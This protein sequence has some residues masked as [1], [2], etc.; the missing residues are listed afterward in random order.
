MP[1]TLYSKPNC[2]G[3]SLSEKVLTKEGIPFEKVDITVDQDAYKHVTEVLGYSAA[4]VIQW[5]NSEGTVGGHFSGFDPDKIRAI[6][7]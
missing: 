2:P 3:C 5:E 6:Q 1:A 4:P 7:R